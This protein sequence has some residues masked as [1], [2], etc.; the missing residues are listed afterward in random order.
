MSELAQYS[1]NWFILAI[2]VLKQPHFGC[3][4]STLKIQLN[5]IFL[6]RPQIKLI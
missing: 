2:Y 6:H 3:F 4:A 1:H 5:K